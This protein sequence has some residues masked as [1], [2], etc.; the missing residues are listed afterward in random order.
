MWFSS[1]AGVS[2]SLSSIKSTSSA[3]KTSASIKCPMR[4]LAITGIVTVAMISRITLIDA[5]RATPP[6]LRMSE[7]TRSSAITAQAPAFSAI[8][9]CSALVTS[10]ITPPLSISAKPTFT[11]H[12]F[13]AFPFPLPFTFFTSMSRFLLSRF[14]PRLPRKRLNFRSR[15][16]TDNH[17]SS[18][19]SRQ[20]ISHGIPD[21]ADVEQAPALVF[22]LPALHDNFFLHADR[23]QILDGKFRG[24][25]AHFA[26]PANLPHGF[27]QQ[28]GDNSA[29]PQPTAA[30]I[31]LAQNK[32]P[33]PAALGSSHAALPFPHLAP[34]QLRQRRR[35]SR[36]LFFVQAGKAQAQRIRQRILRVKIPAW[37]EKHLALFRMNQQ[38][39]GIKSGRQFQPQA[40]TAFRTRPARPFRHVLA[41][42][43]IQ[44]HKPRS[45]HLAHF[46]DMLGKHST[47]QKLRED[48]LRQLIGVNVRSLFHHAQALDGHRGRHDPSHAQSRKRHLRKTIDVNDDVRTIQLLQRGKTVFAR[49]QP[50]INV[51]FHDRHL[52]PR[53][54]LQNFS[55]RSQRHRRSRRILKIRRKHDELHT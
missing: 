27:I 2:T 39:A 9:A 49:V 23:L 12:S 53:G 21:L 32:S 30:L 43:F 51:I 40:H 28:R 4:T 52:M 17:K 47:A 31:P 5:M 14:S 44:R 35:A 13:A 37:R 20:Y 29:V 34:Q 18:F 10:I 46:R 42:R 11:R 38:L 15:R 16:F 26:K 25:R 41:Q 7:G 48:R 55:A 54:Q 22:R 50:P 19:A 24:Y 33:N 1:S 8:C 3:S 45:V 36:N 6:S